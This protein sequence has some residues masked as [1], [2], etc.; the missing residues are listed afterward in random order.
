MKRFDRPNAARAL[1]AGSLT[2][3]LGSCFSSP[4]LESIRY[5]YSPTSAVPVQEQPLT[6]DYNDMAAGWAPP[7]AQGQNQAQNQNQM[8]SSQATLYGRDGSPVSSA[9]PGVVTETK[10]PIND[11][12]DQAPPGS[13]SLLLDLYAEAQ[14]DRERLTTSNENLSMGLEM[15][16]ARA[17]DLEQRL[18]AL[19]EQFDALGREKQ[20]TD[21]KMFDLAARLATAQIARLEAERAL[22]Q[23]T[24]EWRRMSNANN[25]PLTDT[26]GDQ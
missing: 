5:G 10:R 19:E 9:A 14:Q 12:I 4:T 8:E 26:A 17:A 25:R 1:L 7:Q 23:A 24:I 6:D 18:R 11:G 3:F 13:R 22:L 21:Q 2:L 16:E 15:S 20:E